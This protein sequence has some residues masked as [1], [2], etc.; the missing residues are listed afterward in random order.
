MHSEQKVLSL[1][2]DRLE[3]FADADADVYCLMVLGFSATE[4]MRLALIRSPD[5]DEPKVSTCILVT[6]SFLV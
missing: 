5:M 4:G 3:K 1:S 6:Q 2:R